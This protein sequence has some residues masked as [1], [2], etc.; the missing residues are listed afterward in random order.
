MTVRNRGMLPTEA[1]DKF[2]SETNAVVECRLKLTARLVEDHEQ[3]R[4]MQGFCGAAYEWFQKKYGMFCPQQCD[5]KQCKTTCNWLSR[6]KAHTELDKTLSGELTD[7]GETKESLDSQSTK[8]RALEAH[9]VEVKDKLKQ[10][11]TD[12]TAAVKVKEDTTK[13]A[14]TEASKLSELETQ[15]LTKQSE[16]KDGEKALTTEQDKVQ[17][18]QYKIDLDMIEYKRLEDLA[19]GT[20]DD[21]K[22][23]GEQF[24]AEEEEVKKGEKEVLALTEKADA[25]AGETGKA[26]AVAD[27]Q[28]ATVQA[29]ADKLQ[30]AKDTLTAAKNDAAEELVIK[31]F[32]AAVEELTDRFNKVNDEL[33]EKENVQR[34]LETKVKHA[35]QEIATYEAD[36]EKLKKQAE[37]TKK[38]I[39]AMEQQKKDQEKTADDYT[40]T[41]DL[42]KSRDAKQ[43]ADKDLEEAQKSL[44]QAETNVQ[45]AQMAVDEQRKRKG[46]E[47]GRSENADKM[48]NAAETLMANSKEDLRLKGEE[49]K[50]GLW[51]EEQL[52]TAYKAATKDL[53]A[54]VDAHKVEGKSLKKGKP[55]IVVQHGLGLFQSML[56]GEV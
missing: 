31:N 33:F 52:T 38:Q 35:K 54:R 55:E 42:K 26:K 30:R 9:V 6:K 1:L 36:V 27:A 18:A 41:G 23:R 19:K 53:D 14:K 22:E 5:K 12:M 48:Y 17:E 51:D 11:E 2:C 50:E 43:A 44:T 24:A 21:I 28:R 49:L 56:V 32:K 47:Y 39:T 4:N 15:L 37:A 8:M 7:A 40:S 3:G 45:M 29:A 20:D 16:L 10:A 25:K 13:A 46:S 34:K